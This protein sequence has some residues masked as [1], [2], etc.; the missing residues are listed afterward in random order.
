MSSVAR[1]S[2]PWRSIVLACAVLALAG[3][4]H[5]S[6]VNLRWNDCWGDGGP[7]NQAFACNTNVGSHSLVGSFVPPTAVQGF[8]GTEFIV[9]VGFTAA[10]VPAWWMF[11]NAGSCRI[12]SL[13]VA[14][15]PPFLVNCLDWTNGVA[16]GTFTAYNLTPVFPNVAG[17]HG[18]MTEP[19]VAATDL[20]AGEEAFAFRL[21]IN[22]QKTVG[23]GACG[24]CDVGACIS[25]R[26]VVLRTLN[27]SNDR[28]LAIGTSPG[29]LPS[30]ARALWQ[31]TSPAAICDVATPAR[32]R[33]WGEVK[34]LYR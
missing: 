18:T 17:I 3:P 4:V 32:N 8:I 21:Q 30:D 2:A 26:Q 16:L 19:D 12:S 27:G 22:S 31:L 29:D 20:P 23:P 33:T 34:A 25:L 10:A 6:S 5:A 13:T 11:K 28:F 15:A 24:G 14:P 7:A 1:P 9:D